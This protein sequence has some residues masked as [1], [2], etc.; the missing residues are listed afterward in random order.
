MLN[1]ALIQFFNAEME[2]SQH[3]ID[4]VQLSKGGINSPLEALLDHEGA[5]EEARAK[6]CSSREIEVTL[7][8]IPKFLEERSE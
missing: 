7:Q 3:Q 6:L 4:I 5:G 8:K 2:T 1:F